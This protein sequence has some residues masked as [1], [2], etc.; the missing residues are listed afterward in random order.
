MSYIDY[1]QTPI[2]ILEIRASDQGITSVIFPEQQDDQIVPNLHTDQCKEQLSA[3]FEA[4]LT[5]FELTLAPTGTDFQ[6]RVWQELQTIPFGSAVSYSDIAESIG[7]PT[8][9]RAVGAANGR[10]PISIIVPCHRV[11]GSNRSLTGYAGGLARKAWLLE[12]EGVMSHQ[13]TLD[14]KKPA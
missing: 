12:H 8:A 13:Y 7:K 10:N 1:L 6:Q 4:R 11:I 14:I 3:Y 9:V 5:T 2:G